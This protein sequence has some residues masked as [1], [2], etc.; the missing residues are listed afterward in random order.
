MIGSMIKE[1]IKK[2]QYRG[3]SFVI[4]TKYREGFDLWLVFL[5]GLGCAKES[6]EDAFTAKQLDGYSLLAFDF[7]GFGASDKP[8]DFTYTLEDH[9]EI[10]KLVIG[11]LNPSGIVLI[12]HS[13]GGAVGT[14]LAGKLDNMVGYVNLEGN[15]VPEDVGIVSRR[16]AEQPEADFIRHGFSAF[17]QGLKESEDASYRKWA[18]WYGRSSAVAVHRSGCSL[19][20]WSVGGELLPTFNALS[21]KVYVYGDRMD[22]SYLPP[23]LQN[24]DFIAIANSGHF[25][26]I[27]NPD[28][29]YRAIGAC[30]ARWTA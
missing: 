9:V 5:H 30:L 1:E 8:D 17:L 2:V 4:A 14:L 28:D 18:E 29:T 7:V 16:T 21:K 26:M 3:R 12:G 13:M 22:Y 15:L 11:Q 19:V 6:F 24:A 25:M 27:D 20:E 10:A 23:R